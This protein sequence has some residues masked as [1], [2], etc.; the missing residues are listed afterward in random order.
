VLP[1]LTVD[2]DGA[3][4]FVSVKGVGALTPMFGDPTLAG[5]RRFSGE[6]W[7]GEAPFGG[8]GEENARAGLAITALAGGGVSHRGFALC[9][10]LQV[11]EVP[12]SEAHRDTFWYRRHEGPVLQEHRLV[13]SDVRLFH[14]AAHTL[15]QDPDRVLS[16]FGAETGPDLDAFL[17]RMIQTG[18]A[19]LTLFARTARPAADGVAGLVYEHVWLDKDS[20]VAPDGALCFADLEGVDWRSVP[21]DRAADVIVSQLEHNLYEVLFG[22]D[23]VQRVHERV[24]GRPL[25]VGDRRRKVAARVA[26][27]LTDDP[28]VQVE[29]RG[30]SA[31]LRISPAVAAFQ[32]I[33]IRLFDGVK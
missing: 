28:Y 11:V 18:F 27:A 10:V 29:H 12:E 21:A 30:D 25:S 32:P 3:R 26:L 31:W 8:Q 4:W 20:V 9:P 5:A 22:V 1:D 13:P 24:V 15:G 17:E 7:F 19:A 14:A 16:A 23:T 2:V 33:E 6:R